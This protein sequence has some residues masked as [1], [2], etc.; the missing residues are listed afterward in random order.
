[1]PRDLRDR[2]PTRCALR[3][4][5]VRL[6]GDDGDGDR[7][8]VG[9]RVLAGL[10]DLGPE[11]GLAQRRVGRVDLQIVLAGALATGAQQ[12]GLL[13]VLLAVVVG[14]DHGAAQRAAGLGGTLAAL[15]R[16][17]QIVELPDPGPFLALLLTRGGVA[18]V[19]LEV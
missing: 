16:G 9:C 14:A 10:V 12:E 19:L 7:L 3:S 6:L 8:A 17:Q 11:D 13:G 2:L 1:R 15:R 4:A 18:G 5:V